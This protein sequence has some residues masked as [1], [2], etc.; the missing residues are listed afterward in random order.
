[1]LGFVAAEVSGARREEGSGAENPGFEFRVFGFRRLGVL[2]FGLMALIRGSQN[3]GGGGTGTP[4]WH[5][6]RRTQETGTVL[7]AAG[8]LG[9]YHIRYMFVRGPHNKEYFILGPYV[10]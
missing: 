5:I 4:Q 3:W 7:V 6:E 10:L 8:I 2:G 1:M 9:N